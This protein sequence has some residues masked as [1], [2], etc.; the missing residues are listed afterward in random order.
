MVRVIISLLKHH[1]NVI[2]YWFMSSLALSFS[3]NA[4]IHSSLPLKPL[5][6]SDKLTMNEAGSKFSA[7][8]GF[9]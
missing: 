4:L 2:Y 3:L 8:S 9:Q 5:S 7:N 1:Y 6:E